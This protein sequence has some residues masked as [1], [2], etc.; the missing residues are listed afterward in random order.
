MS[1]QVIPFPR[2]QVYEPWVTAKQ[3]M[4]HF[5]ISLMTVDRWV[6]K[7]MPCEKFGR[8]RMFKLSECEAWARDH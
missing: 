5:Q 2:Q 1:A 7:G 6:A 8:K 3:V 4:T